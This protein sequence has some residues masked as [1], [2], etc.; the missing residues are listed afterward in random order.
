MIHPQSGTR[1]YYDRHGDATLLA[2]HRLLTHYLVV[3]YKRGAASYALASFAEILDALPVESV[4][5][6]GVRLT[7]EATLDAT[8]DGWLNGARCVLRRRCGE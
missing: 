2:Y 5:L 7:L 8:L 3:V 6:A 1:V 4:P